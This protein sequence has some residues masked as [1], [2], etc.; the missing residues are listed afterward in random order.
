MRNNHRNWPENFKATA[1]MAIDEPDKIDAVGI[2]G[3]TTPGGFAGTSFYMPDD[4][5]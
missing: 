1:I 3:V 4:P 2:E 5:E